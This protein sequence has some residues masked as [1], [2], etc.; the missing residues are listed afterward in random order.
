MPPGNGEEH[1]SHFGGDQFG[2]AI[3]FDRAVRLKTGWKIID[4]AP[5]RLAGV[6]R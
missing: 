1:A 3:G 5:S 4:L 6:K 2:V